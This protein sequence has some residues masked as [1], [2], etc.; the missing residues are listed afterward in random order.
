MAEETPKEFGSD[1]KGQAR[2]WK[3]ELRLSGK[4]EE[5]WRKDVQ[6]VIERYRGE[7]MRE[8]NEQGGTRLKR[9]AFNILW[10]NTE[11]LRPALYNSTPKP[12]V[13][14]RFTD[15]SD[16]VAKAVSDVLERALTYSVD[17]Y[18][19]DRTMVTAI[20]DYLLP[21]RSVVKVKYEASMK[22]GDTEEVEEVDYEE[23][24]CEHVQWQDFRRGPGRSWPEVPWIAFAYRLTRDQ[25][26]E[27]FGEELGSQI[28]LNVSLRNDE[29]RDEDDDKRAFDRA[30]IW[31]VWD[32]L[33]KNVVWVSMEEESVLKT[34]DDP[35]N[36]GEFFPIPRPLLSM[37]SST[38]LVPVPEFSQYETLASEL[39]KCQARIIRILEGL[40]LRGLYDSTMAEI[41]QLFNAGDNKMIGVENLAKI[42]QMGGLNNGIWMLDIK[43]YAEV[44]M[45]LY[46]YRNGLLQSIYEVTGIS[47]ILRGQSDH[48]ETARAQE[49]KS[50]WGT[51]RLQ[52]R[53]RDI[54]RF[55]RDL[56]R[57]K[58]ELIAENF[59][60]DT[61]RQMTGL[62]YPTNAQRMQAMFGLRSLEQQAQQAQQ[63]QAPL[64]PQLQQAMAQAKE[65]L[66]KPT[67]EQI[68]QVMKNDLLRH[69]KIDIETDSTIAEQMIED[70]QEVANMMKGLVDFSNGIGPA[71]Q[72][73][74]LPPKA[75]KAILLAA[76]RRFK[77]GEQ[78]EDAI[79]EADIGQVQ[80]QP[81]PNAEKARME[82]QKMMMDQKAA[83]EK[84]QSTM[85]KM[86]AD[87]Q[88]FWQKH[89]ARMQE[90]QAEAESKVMVQ[91]A[92]A[93]GDVVKAQVSR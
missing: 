52:K 47:D 72:S 80:Q 38:S 65:I 28:K 64:T 83:Q 45:H 17:A 36:L 21:G 73:G 10:S 51:L 35:L 33:A 3:L 23:V 70:K 11:T 13:R 48:R 90:I 18:D 78:V 19:F 9:N 54:Q 87:M 91:E 84:H 76:L 74:L 32:K 57:L 49:I 50:N 27:R 42:T 66:D 63:M 41:G 53:Q 34:E 68:Q 12:R 16:K 5:N 15:N 59:S 8:N 61:L 79:E 30:L 39:D 22:Q 14:K 71:M 69:Y 24:E 58:A 20:D 81:D 29:D 1:P 6:R 40:R 77:L 4:Q 92:Q 44:L 25:L 88:A 26:K 2:R 62:N 60:I 56:F 7:Y 67:W 93:R 46:T 89:Q 86:Q 43:G 37:E 75:V 82:M 55:A 31:Q 85:D